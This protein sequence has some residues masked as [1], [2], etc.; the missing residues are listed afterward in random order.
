MRIPEKRCA[1]NSGIE[2]MRARGKRALYTA[3]N[4]TVLLPLPAEA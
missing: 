2:Y 4:Y 3:L 1:E